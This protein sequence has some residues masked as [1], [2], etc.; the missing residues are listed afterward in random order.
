MEFYNCEWLVE[1][2]MVSDGMVVERRYLLIDL[3]KVARV[4]AHVVGW[5]NGGDLLD[6]SCHSVC[7]FLWV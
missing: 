2:V 3:V 4:E 6:V 5:A 7:L 1:V